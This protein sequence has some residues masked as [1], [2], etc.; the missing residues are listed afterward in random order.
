MYETLGINIISALRTGSN[1]IHLYICFINNVP[2]T[3][4]N[5]VSNKSIL[6]NKVC[7]VIQMIIKCSHYKNNVLHISNDINDNELFLLQEYCNWSIQ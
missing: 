3:E 7:P 6:K 5:N 4:I 1:I 2:N